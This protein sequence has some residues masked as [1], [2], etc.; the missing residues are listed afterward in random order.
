[1]CS[2]PSVH[3]PI[4][5]DQNSAPKREQNVPVRMFPRISGKG[6][7]KQRPTVRDVHRPGQFLRSDRSLGP[8]YHALPLHNPRRQYRVPQQNSPDPDSP[9][10]NSPGHRNMPRKK[11]LRRAQPRNGSAQCRNRPRD[12]QRQPCLTLPLRKH[13]SRHGRICRVNRLTVCSIPKME[14]A[15][16]A[17]GAARSASP[18][19]SKN[20]NITHDLCYRRIVNSRPSHVELLFAPQRNGWPLSWAEGRAYRFA[21]GRTLVEAGMMKRF[22][23]PAGRS[24]GSKAFVSQSP[25]RS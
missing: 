23:T 21:H 13:G 5:R 3:P 1:M 12:W 10:R 7:V 18:I 20:P 4:C 11:L 19:I 9:E 14:R 22:H 6:A 8:M 2:C 17:N 24:D 15:I 16:G 25:R